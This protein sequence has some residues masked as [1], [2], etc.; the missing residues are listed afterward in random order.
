MACGIVENLSA[1][2]IK[3]SRHLAFQG[4]V[5]A[6]SGARW[7]LREGSVGGLQPVGADKKAGRGRGLSSTQAKVWGV[8]CPSSQT[9]IGALSGVARRGASL[10]A[11][12]MGGLPALAE[13]GEA[14]TGVAAVVDQSTI[15]SE[16]R[17][18]FANIVASV[19]LAPQ[20]V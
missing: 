3:G 19:L 13:L 5:R 10:I 11:W 14:A 1:E 18:M 6:Q 2:G 15:P 20:S 7:L 17:Q 16:V 4:F 9:S 8:V 12:T